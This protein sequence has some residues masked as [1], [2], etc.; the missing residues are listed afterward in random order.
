LIA[1]RDSILERPGRVKWTNR[2][3]DLKG[4]NITFKLLENNEEINAYEEN[5]RCATEYHCLESEFGSI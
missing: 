4:S 5:E 1:S 3:I 2:A